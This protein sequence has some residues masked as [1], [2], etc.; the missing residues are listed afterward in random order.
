MPASTLTDAERDQ[1]GIWGM[2]MALSEV[3]AERKG[4]AE[5]N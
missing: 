4:H 1:I 5:K 2:M 3:S